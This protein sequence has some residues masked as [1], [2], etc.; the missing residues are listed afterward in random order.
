MSIQ[1]Y[2]PV[3][4]GT[5]AQ[6]GVVCHCLLRIFSPLKIRRLRPGL[7]PRTWVLKAST[8]PLDHRNRLYLI[9]I[10]LGRNFSFQFMDL[11]FQRPVK[12]SCTQC[13]QYLLLIYTRRLSTRL[14][15]LSQLSYFVS[16]PSL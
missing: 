5:R 11:S 2:G 15:G 13:D 14:N 1:P 6:S 3:L 4:A 10:F 16:S 9:F 12:P 8:L 7:N